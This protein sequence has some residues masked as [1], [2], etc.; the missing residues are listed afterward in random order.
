MKPR[1][2]RN[3]NR[4]RALRA[5]RSRKRAPRLE[6]P[7]CVAVQNHDGVLRHS[8]GCPFEA[9]SSAVSAD[10]RD[11]FET[12]PG[13]T[14]RCRAPDMTEMYLLAW[15]GG[16]ALPPPPPGHRW[17]PTGCVEVQQIRPGVRIRLCDSL[18]VIAQ[19]VGPS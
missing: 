8:D 18:G 17:Q 15:T 6:C 2:D 14:T 5:A 4:R 3:T 13:A 12:H 16:M 1:R 7:D 10:D 11:W 19:P 9:A